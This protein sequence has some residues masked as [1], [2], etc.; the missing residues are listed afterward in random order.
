MAVGQGGD[1]YEVERIEGVKMVKHE[2]YYYIFWKGYKSTDVGA[3]TWE[4][5]R[6]VGMVWLL[7]FW[8]K[9]P[10]QLARLQ[11]ISASGSAV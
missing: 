11:S 7:D 3:R 9:D 2:F 8:K 4:P 10:E 1:V 6:N 5:E